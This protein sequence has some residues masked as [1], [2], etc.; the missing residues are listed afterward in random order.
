MYVTDIVSVWRIFRTVE[1]CCET[2]VF[3]LYIQYDYKALSE[4]FWEFEFTKEKK[5]LS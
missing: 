2:L 4:E 1:Q 5:K 3:E